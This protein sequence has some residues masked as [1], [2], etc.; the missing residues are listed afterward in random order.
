MSELK[1]IIALSRAKKSEE[2]AKKK[3]IEAEEALI[4]AFGQRDEGSKTHTVEDWS[5]TITAKVTR[6][7]DWSKWD[8]TKDAIPENHRPVKMKPELDVKGVKWLQENDPKSYTVLAA[9]LTSKPGKTAVTIKK[10]G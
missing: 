3:R 10:K 9:C 4:D 6:S 1:L 2:T 7:M 5:V 8:A